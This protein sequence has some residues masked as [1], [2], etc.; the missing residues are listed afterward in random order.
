[1]TGPGIPKDRDAIS[2]DWMRQALIAGGFPNTPPIDDVVVTDIGA[3]VGLLAEILRCRLVRRGRNAEVV[4]ETVIVKLPSTSP[5]SLRMSRLQSLY[6]REYDYYRRVA[7]DLPVRSPR[8]FYGAWEDRGHRFVL[9]LEDLADMTP[10]DHAAGATPDQARLA[11]RT[12]ARL[13]GRYWNYTR[14]PVLSGAFDTTG[15]KVRP[16][17]QVL[18]LACLIPTFKR[19][20]HCF[21]AGMR[22]LA[23]AY[24]PL[25]AHHIAGT[26]SS[27]PRT[28]IHGDYRL[29]NLFFGAGADDVALI[30]WQ[31]SGLGCGL[32]DVAYF[33]GASVTTQVRREIERD[34]LR[35]YTEILVESASGAREFTFDE[36]WHLYRS[37]MLG[38][39]LISIF[40]CG[41]LDVR[42]ERARALAESGLRRTLAAIED[43]R[44]ADFLPATPPRLS[45]AN[46]FSTMSRWAYRVHRAVRGR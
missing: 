37:H 44:A 35:E 10:G 15:S 39:L 43:L 30:D 11:I 13:H 41:G 3:G 33:L 36:C 25:V 32:Y 7:P 16:L 46:L 4:P 42:D 20:G 40:V 26:A 31:V 9:V 27:A 45:G 17:Y 19:F 6:K 21:S 18:Y 34:A 38:R 14:Q 5:K 2:A 8:L 28:F 12:L 1:M 22:R 29:D 24:G 23:E